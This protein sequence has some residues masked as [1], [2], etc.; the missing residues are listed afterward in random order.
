MRRFRA[1][2]KRHMVPPDGTG[3]IDGAECRAGFVLETEDSTDRVGAMNSGLPNLCSK[4][5]ARLSRAREAKRG[6]RA[7]APASARLA[8][9]VLT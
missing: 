5:F 4:R 2:V 9:A 7:P 1:G 8:D 6:H 3:R